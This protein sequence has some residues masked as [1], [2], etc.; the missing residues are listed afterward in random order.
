MTA[1]FDINIL[2]LFRDV[3]EVLVTFNLEVF[4]EE[5]CSPMVAKLVDLA[6]SLAGF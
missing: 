5:A 3:Y 2:V 4:Y 6:K 1:Q